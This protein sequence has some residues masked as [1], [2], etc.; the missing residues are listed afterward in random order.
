MNDPTHTEPR[1]HLLTAR[2]VSAMYEE[3][4]RQQP[5]PSDGWESCDGDPLDYRDAA[6]RWAEQNAD[7]RGLPPAGRGREG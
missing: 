4:I 5:P 3:L 7:E 2:E 1:R 6:R